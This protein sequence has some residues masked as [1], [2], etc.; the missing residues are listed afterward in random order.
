MSMPVALSPVVRRPLRLWWGVVIAS[1]S[2]AAQAA[3]LLTIL[4]GDALLIQ[5]TQAQAAAEGV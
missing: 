3:G 2:L 4:D 1:W 5:G